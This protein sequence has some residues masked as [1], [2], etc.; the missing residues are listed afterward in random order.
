MASVCLETLACPWRGLKGGSLPLGRKLWRLFPRVDFFWLC[1]EVDEGGFF[2]L[3]TT[4]D[5]AILG[6]A[7]RIHPGPPVSGYL[8]TI[9][10]SRSSLEASGLRERATPESFT[11]PPSP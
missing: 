1:G 8:S 3:A 5:V 6:D 9:F 11:R 4:V 7:H 2:C 10:S